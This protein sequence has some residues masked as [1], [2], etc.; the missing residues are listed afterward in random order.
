MKCQWRGK[1]KAFF[2]SF[3]C[4]D[5]SFLF[6]TTIEDSFSLAMVSMEFFNTQWNL[7]MKSEV[8]L[9]GRERRLQTLLLNP[10]IPMMKAGS[11]EW[12]WVIQF[13]YRSHSF[14]LCWISKRSFAMK[15]KIELSASSTDAKSKKVSFH[16]QVWWAHTIRVRYHSALL[17][18]TKQR[19]WKS[20]ARSKNRNAKNN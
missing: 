19:E 17:Q 2:K 8:F 5:F 18:L 6:S 15:W 14:W 12:W 4:H 3:S 9:A 1:E 11:I 20:F 7:W 16:T 13:R 10:L